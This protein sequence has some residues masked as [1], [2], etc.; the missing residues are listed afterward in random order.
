[1]AKNVKASATENQP[2]TEAVR[3]DTT[4]KDDPNAQIRRVFRATNP[5][6]K[7]EIATLNRKTAIVNGTTQQALFLTIPV[8]HVAQYILDDRFEKDEYSEQL[9]TLRR[10][11]K[12]GTVVEMPP[13]WEGTLFVEPAPLTPAEIRAEELRLENEALLAEL[14]ELK[15]GKARINEE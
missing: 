5:L 10:Y 2:K 1:M 8:N 13:H 9:K 14:K 6:T 4:W 7:V 11:E 12:A 15:E 3:E